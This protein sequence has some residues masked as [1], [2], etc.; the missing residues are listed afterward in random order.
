MIQN[1][2]EASV[3]ESRESSLNVVPG[4]D[5]DGGGESYQT[6]LKKG[7]MSSDKLQQF[8]QYIVLYQVFLSRQ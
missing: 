6:A 5:S 4:P 7:F 2:I 3:V 1:Y 8:H